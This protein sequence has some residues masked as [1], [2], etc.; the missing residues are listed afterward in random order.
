MRNTKE[1]GSGIMKRLLFVCVSIIAGLCLLGIENKASSQQPVLTPTADQAT[2]SQETTSPLSETSC[3][4]GLPCRIP[5]TPLVVQALGDY[6]GPF[7]EDG[8]DTEMRGACVI[9]ENTSEFYVERARVILLQNGNELVFEVTFLPPKAQILVIEKNMRLF[10]MVG[11]DS[12]RCEDLSILQTALRDERVYVSGDGDCSM[13]VTNLTDTPVNRV[14]IHYKQYYPESDLYFG[15]ITYT[16]EVFN[17]S[18]GESR[19]ITPYH[20]LTDQGRILAVTAE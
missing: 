14:Q 5:E 13:I 15:G 10:S 2:V 3:I 18:P 8:S 12:C 9:L 17:L 6:E 20:Y 19:R 1:S 11:V 16:A 4:S 7:L